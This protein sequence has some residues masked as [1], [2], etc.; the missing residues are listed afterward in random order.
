[1]FLLMILFF[2][3][4]CSVPFYFGCFLLYHMLFFANYYVFT[5]PLWQCFVLF[6][7]LYLISYFY[8]FCHLYLYIVVLIYIL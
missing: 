3:L 7:D 2:L 8:L 5:V 4:Y 1:M 6:C